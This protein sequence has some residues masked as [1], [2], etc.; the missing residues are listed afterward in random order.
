LYGFKAGG[1]NSKDRKVAPMH[2]IEGKISNRNASFEGE[3]K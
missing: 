1:L 2:N 3:N